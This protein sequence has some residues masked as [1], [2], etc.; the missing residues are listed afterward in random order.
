MTRKLSISEARSRLPELAH[1]VARSPGAVEYIEH[2]DLDETL[3][4][5]TKSHLEY[6]EATVKEL[7]KKVAV[8]FTLAGSLAAGADDAAL[9]AALDAMREEQAALADTKLGELAG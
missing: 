8:P 1:R 9:E 7:R 2:R 4:L 6:L 3:A 5:T